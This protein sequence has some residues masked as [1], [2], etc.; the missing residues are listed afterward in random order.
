MVE[1]ILK[2]IYIE[3]V[4]YRFLVKK[5]NFEIIFYLIVYFDNKVCYNMEVLYDILKWKYVEFFFL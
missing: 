3:F 1:G 2:N 5:K 4:I